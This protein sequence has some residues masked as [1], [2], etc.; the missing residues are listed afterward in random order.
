MHN[1][2]YLH[3]TENPATSLVSPVLDSNNYHLWNRSFVKALS[4]KN[5]LEFILG[6]YPCGPKDD[7]TFAAWSQCNNIVVSWLVHSVSVPIR[8][9]IRM[10]VT[11][12]I[13]NDLKVRYSQGDF[14]RISYLQLEGSSLS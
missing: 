4:A 1:S 11:F 6:F 8:Q 14:S 5:K 12:D 9:S 13:W 2:L 10:D 3:P 7:P